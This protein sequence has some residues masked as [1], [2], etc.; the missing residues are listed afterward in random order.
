MSES[1]DQAARP[2]HFHE[3]LDLPVVGEGRSGL[4]H[5]AAGDD[6]TRHQELLPHTAVADIL[7]VGGE[8]GKGSEIVE[9]FAVATGLEQVPRPAEDIGHV[10][11]RHGA[12]ASGLA[13]LGEKA[14]LAGAQ[15]AP[16][17]V[18]TDPNVPIGGGNI[19]VTDDLEVGRLE[20]K[21]NIALYVGG[22]GSRDRNFHNKLVSRMGFEDAATR[23]QDLYLD[24]KKSD[25][26]A[27]VPDELVDEISLVGPKEVIRQRL[28]AWEDSAVTGLLVWP[29]TTKDIA[30]FAELVLG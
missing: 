3:L 21:Q 11:G 2:R 8:P 22:M 27:A 24:G 5:G 15:P 18:G 20:V 23:I 4:A 1:T 6:A 19:H 30:T 12:A 13:L 26:I 10:A 14:A 16:C 17:I 7:L 25:A 28:A 9:R 29:K